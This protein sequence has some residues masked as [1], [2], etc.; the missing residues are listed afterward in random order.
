MDDRQHD[1]QVW[2]SIFENVASEWLS[3]PPSDLMR[4]CLHYFRRH[5]GRRMLDLGSGFG[6]WSVFFAENLGI[7]VTGV[8]YAFG[9]NLLGTRLAE[10]RRCN[11]SFV[12]CEITA[13]PFQRE[14]FDNFVAVLILDNLA[15][16]HARAAVW[17]MTRVLKA[18]AHGVV[19]LNPWPVGA[20]DESTNPTATCTRRDYA[21][22][23]VSSLLKPLRVLASS[24]HEHGFR[25]FEVELMT[26]GEP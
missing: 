24:R 9:G 14:Q 4:Q 2:Q 3:T 13:L 26:R 22:E 7:A 16:E 10:Q 21:D 5:P 6:R 19:V 8:D 12:T 11:A 25:A 18:K 20:P 15:E 1:Q 17:E 23:E